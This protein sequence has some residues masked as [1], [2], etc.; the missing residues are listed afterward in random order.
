[1]KGIMYGYYNRRDLPNTPDNG[2]VDSAAGGIYDTVTIVATK[3]GS[4]ASGQI[5]GVDNLDEIFIV[6]LAGIATWSETANTSFVA[7]LDAIIPLTGL[8]GS[9]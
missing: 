5:H 7:K 8:Y 1:M 3:D 9:I 4:S 6:G 2:A